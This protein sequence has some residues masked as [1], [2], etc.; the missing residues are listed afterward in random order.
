V[1][2]GSPGGVPAVTM[3]GVTE[4][5]RVQLFQ[6]DDVEVSLP[7]GWARTMSR[8]GVHLLVAGP[9]LGW[10][11]AIVGEGGVPLLGFALDHHMEVALLEH[12]ERWPSH[13][14]LLPYGDLGQGWWGVAQLHDG[15]VYLAQTDFD[16]LSEVAAGASAAL[17]A[18][19]EV[20]VDG[21]HVSWHRVPVEVYDRAWAVT[22]AHVGETA[23]GRGVT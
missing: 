15:W 16:E 5:A 17:V 14:S 6:I 10:M 13:S 22:L 18:P 12:P 11:A 21:V 1:D 8:A 2:D 23:A 19:G 7:L 9:D 4:G 20:E 3:T